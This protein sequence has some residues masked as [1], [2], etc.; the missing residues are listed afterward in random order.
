MAY[1]SLGFYC[2]FEESQRIPC[3]LARS[4]SVRQ[5]FS[6]SEL[7][8]GSD[9]FMV[10]PLPRFIFLTDKAK[11]VIDSTELEGAIFVPVEKLPVTEHRTLGPGRL[12]YWMPKERAYELGGSMGSN[13]DRSPAAVSTASFRITR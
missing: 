2:A 1:R 10:W 13:K 3:S 9:F 7:W 12:S 5:Q 6:T 11:Q 8:D 4:Y